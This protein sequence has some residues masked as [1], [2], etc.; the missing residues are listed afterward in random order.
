MY[1]YLK[2]I[3]DISAKNIRK[4]FTRRD[5]RRKVRSTYSVNFVKNIHDQ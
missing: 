4:I 1:T 2:Q 3:P 5:F